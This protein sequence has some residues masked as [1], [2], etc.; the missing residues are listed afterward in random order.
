MLAKLPLRN[1]FLYHAMGTFLRTKPENVF[2][3]LM[4]ST[5]QL[6][7]ELFTWHNTC[8]RRKFAVLLICIYYGIHLVGTIYLL[9]EHPRFLIEFF[10]RQSSFTSPE[11]FAH[12]PLHCHLLIYLRNGNN[13]KLNMIRSLQKKNTMHHHHH[14]TTIKSFYYETNDHLT[15]Q[16]SPGGRGGRLT[17]SFHSPFYPPIMID[18]F[19]SSTQA[20]HPT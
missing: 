9:S 12:V 4:C 20:P 1:K 11:Q 17:S 3:I 8:S 19:L 6:Q 18:S 16:G 7:L 13:S 14:R 5:R 15:I 10:L 2:E